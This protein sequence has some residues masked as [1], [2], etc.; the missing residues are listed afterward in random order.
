[1][2]LIIS[3][4]VLAFLSVYFG[5]F[6]DKEKLTG[7][8]IFLFAL[9]LGIYSYWE[10]IS[11]K[12]SE[13]DSKNRDIELLHEIISS[14]D[15]VIDQFKGQAKNLVISTE[16]FY[17]DEEV[18]YRF[19]IEIG[20]EDYLYDVSIRY[21]PPFEVDASKKN[22]LYT[23]QTFDL[24]KIVDIGNLPNQGWSYFGEPIAIKK[25]EEIYYRFHINTRNDMY[26]FTLIGKRGNA[27][28]IKVAR[29]LFRNEFIKMDTITDRKVL[30]NLGH[31]SLDTF[32][33]HKKKFICVDSF[34]S[35][36]FPI[37]L[38]NED[39]FW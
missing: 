34:V 33:R 38:S 27:P 3:A 4:S 28:R 11:N 26:W 17:R 39:Y 15:E 23:A 8:S 19:K 37:N 30:D 14:K 20:P 29:K 36:Q 6:L 13:I 7:L 1:M 2:I 22:E 31:F 24:Y 25:G 21:F 32:L 18:C 16:P 10:G 9:F 5:I 12:N 35:R